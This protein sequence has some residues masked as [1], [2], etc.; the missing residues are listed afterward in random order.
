MT[1]T[2]TATTDEQIEQ[3]FEAIGV[4]ICADE[5]V[6]TAETLADFR[7][8]R[9][10]W[11]KPGIVERSTDGVLV[12]TDCAAMAGQ[13]RQTLAVIDFGDCRLAARV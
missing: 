7:D 6:R 9:R 4:S 10:G 5:A 3:A 2:T 8:A 11:A 12:V 1:T 13:R